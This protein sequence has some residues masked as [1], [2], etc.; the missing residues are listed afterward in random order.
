VVAAEPPIVV[1]PP[2]PE[3]DP[4]VVAEPQ[5]ATLVDVHA[6]FWWAWDA[7]GSVWLLPAYTFT[8]TEDRQHMVPAVTDEFLVVEDVPAT[9][10]PTQPVPP[11]VD[12]AAVVGLT[13]D[14]ATKVLA[15]LGLTLRVVREDGVDL[16][17]TADFSETRV[18]VAVETG[19]VTAVVSLG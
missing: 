11:D 4:V 6:D 2:L 19:T 3:E 9:T 12:P 17:V 18:N 10:V 8:D 14:E 15:E 1:D 7:D 13:V 16:P 5:V